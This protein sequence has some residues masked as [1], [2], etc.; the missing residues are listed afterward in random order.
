MINKL[1]PGRE[2]NLRTPSFEWDTVRCSAHGI[3]ATN[4]YLFFDGQYSELLHFPADCDDVN[5]RFR[6]K[7]K[8]DWGRVRGGP[9]I[10]SVSKECASSEHVDVMLESGRPTDLEGIVSRFFS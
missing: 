3:H 5:A 1:L 7:L 2:V 9:S 4:K 6:L 10:V 8:W